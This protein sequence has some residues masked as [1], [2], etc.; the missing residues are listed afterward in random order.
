MRSILQQY[1]IPLSKHIKDPLLG[2]VC[3]AAASLIFIEF[4]SVFISLRSIGYT[5]FE[6]GQYEWAQLVVS[7]SFQ[8]YVWAVCSNIGYILI[9]LLYIFIRK[10][11]HLKD[12]GLR[13]PSKSSLG[14]YALMLVA[15]LLVVFIVSFEASFQETYPFYRYSDGGS[16]WWEGITWELL[17][18][19]QFVGV[20]FFFRGFLIHGTKAQLGVNSVYFA[21][22]PYV[23]IHFSKPLPECLGSIF[24][25]LILGHLSY[26][27]QS[28]WGGVFLHVCVA[29]SMDFLSMWHRGLL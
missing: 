17:Y 12:M 7:E 18:A 2:F 21:L 29:M 20:E 8:L 28:I 11:L 16:F 25:G 15:I 13:L 9:P 24:A 23:M 19:L 5:L 22:I 27:T 14:L 10:D 3:V 26:K 6:R 4:Y 1:L